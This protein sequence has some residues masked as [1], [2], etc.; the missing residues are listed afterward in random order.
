MEFR[1]HNDALTMTGVCREGAMMIT[2]GYR[3]DDGEMTGVTHGTFPSPPRP[4]P[5]EK[6]K[7]SQKTFF[8]KRDDVG[9]VT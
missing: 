2:G 6:K 1:E 7:F 9:G 5:F 4:V 8:F 3:G